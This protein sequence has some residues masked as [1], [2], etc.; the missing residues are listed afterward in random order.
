M[1]PLSAVSIA[2]SLVTFSSTTLLL[3]QNL[4]RS[5]QQINSL[6]EEI[7]ILQCILDESKNTID[8]AQAVPD[9]VGMSL[10]LC[11]QKQITLLIT[12]QKAK[13][14]SDDSPFKRMFR[15]YM[16]AIDEPRVMSA[17]RSF[18]SSVLVLRDLTADMR[19]YQKM[20]DISSTMALL[21]A[22]GEMTGR[23]R[24]RSIN[25]P[26]GP[27][28]D[29]DSIEMDHRPG[30]TAEGRLRGNVPY[31]DFVT[32]LH[33]DFTRDLILV[34]E[35]AGRTG[36]DKFEFVPLRNKIDTASDENFISRK[37][38]QKY[39]MNMNKLVAIPDRRERTLEGI[40]GSFTPEQEV[41]LH[42]HKLQDRQQREGRFIVL[43]DPPFDVLIGSK[44]FA[45]ECRPAVM[46]GFGKHIPKGQKK[47]QEED[48]AQRRK[49]AERQIK[50][51]LEQAQKL[52]KHMP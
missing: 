10:D 37:V 8:A 23:S 35:V 45:N 34:I 38:L 3:V 30:S 9:S 20:I 27:G 31:M 6:T 25:H 41:T 40:G 15:L 46:F 47:K 2:A 26:A 5:E 50:E 1:D 29:G 7:T 22:E 39:D 14:K 28:D 19:M 33:T 21:M 12:L 24:G 13:P 52:K 48:H 51:Q 4:A 11:N 16:L 49:D 32:L 44:Q 36:L 42:W 43:D 18:R 17:Y